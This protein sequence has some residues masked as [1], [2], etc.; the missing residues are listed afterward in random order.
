[1]SSLPFLVTLP[2]FSLWRESPGGRSHS[3]DFLNVIDEIKAAE[4]SNESKDS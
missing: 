3:R 1:L 4:N 2:V